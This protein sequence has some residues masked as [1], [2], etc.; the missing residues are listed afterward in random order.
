V[1]IGAVTE[2]RL[3]TE[4][5]FGV[6]SQVARVATFLGKRIEYVNEVVEYLP[7]KRLATRSVRAP[8]P[9]TVTYE[10]EDASPGTLVRI[11][12]EGDP[13]G[14]YRVAGPLLSRAVRRGIEGDLGRLK[15]TLETPE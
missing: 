11:H 3:V 14:F 5:P 4:P 13:S 10:F 9:M 12:A 15:A 1:W 6:S 7:G 2:A 8:F